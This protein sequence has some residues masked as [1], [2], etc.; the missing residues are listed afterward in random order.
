MTRTPFFDFSPNLVSALMQCE[1]AYR[2][3]PTLSEEES[4]NNALVSAFHL[5]GRAMLSGCVSSLCDSD[6]WSEQALA[7]TGLV[8]GYRAALRD[9]IL[10]SDHSDQPLSSE[11]LQR[12]MGW[13]LSEGAQQKSAQYRGAGQRFERPAVFGAYQPPSY[14]DIEDEMK[15]LWQW[16]SKAS[17]MPAL[18]R[19][20]VA[21]YR[22]VSIQPFSEHPFLA[23]SLVARA[24][25]LRDG[26]AAGGCLEEIWL[27]DWRKFAQWFGDSAR[28]Q[29]YAGR[30]YADLTEWL[31]YVV[32]GATNF[33]Q[34]RRKQIDFADSQQQMRKQNDSITNHLEALLAR[35]KTAEI[36][37]AE[38]ARA[39]ASV[40]MFIRDSVQKENQASSARSNEEKAEVNAAVS[41]ICLLPTRD[42]TAFSITPP[43]QITSAD[44]GTNDAAY[45]NFAEENFSDAEENLEIGRREKRLL[46]WFSENEILTGKDVRRIFKLQPRTASGLCADWV[47]GNLLE[48]L[49]PSNKARSY[50][51]GEALKALLQATAEEAKPE[52]I[53]ALPI[54]SELRRLAKRP[55]GRRGSSSKKLLAAGGM[56]LRLRD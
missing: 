20:S 56:R 6:A 31:F 46:K 43:Q 28:R 23:A 30:C 29:T 25:M 34:L 18:V 44:A 4:I 26:Y 39:R 51:A 17:D 41:N 15:C 22:V 42:I 24:I 52:K 47:A 45:G 2:L 11:I 48:V 37:G 38:R 53:S 3:L 36:D 40:S 55:A 13:V 33:Y 35:R 32:E 19:A 16:L 7:N 54:Q 21:F 8:Q 1:A 50:S 12:F 5:E 27:R 10:W 49:D 9:V 14:A